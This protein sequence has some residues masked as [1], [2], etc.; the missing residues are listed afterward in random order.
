MLYLLQDDMLNGWFLQPYRIG[1]FSR[2]KTR[3]CQCS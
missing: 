3:F 1:R 2:E